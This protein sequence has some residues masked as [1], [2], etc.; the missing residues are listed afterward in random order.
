MEI[1]RQNHKVNRSTGKI[2]A[3]E[4]DNALLAAN[5]A[6]RPCPPSSVWDLRFSLRLSR[7]VH[8]DHTIAL[9]GINYEI[10]ATKRKV[11]TIMHHPDS[12]FWVVEHPP[13]V[14]W[15]PVLAAFTLEPPVPFCSG[16]NSPF[17]PSPTSR[18]SILA[19][20]IDLL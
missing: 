11:V 3:H 6:M 9:A 16:K 5:S 20:R 2:P 12:Q 1:C 7:R 10:S 13:K 18:G 15:H 4:W 8:D 19:S 14:V 17:V